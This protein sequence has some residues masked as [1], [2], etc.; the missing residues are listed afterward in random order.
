VSEASPR[1]G[2][3]LGLTAAALFGASAPA[4][5]LLL[6]SAKPLVLAA[7]LY[8]GAGLAL[9]AFI[10]LRGGRSDEARLR[11]SD[12][13]SMLIILVSGGMLGPFLMLVG[14][15]RLSAVSGSLLL[16]L[17]APFTMLVAVLFFREHLGGVAALGALCI[18]GGGALLG[19]SPGELGGDWLGVAAIAGACL[20]WAIDNN[21]TQKLSVRDPIAVVRVKTLGA[22]TCNLALALALGESLPSPSLVGATLLLGSLAY[23]LSVLLDMKALRILG[24]AREAAYFA[25]APFVGALLAIPLHG[26]WPSW[27]D[28]AGAL[29]MLVGVGLL[30][31]ERHRHVHTHE[32]LEHDHLHTHDEHH[33]HAHDGPVNEPHAHPHRHEPITHDHPHVPD[34]HHRHRH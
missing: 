12:V 27:V 28:G 34:V 25:M 11:R 13:G 29:A 2:A 22:G 17:E 33:D 16:N 32:P 10:A 20:A 14:L 4:A 31:R 18:V 5:K 1:R 26:V 24:A 3:V 9:S 6:P 30:V 7:L 15:A 19:W 8:L 21:T 23:G